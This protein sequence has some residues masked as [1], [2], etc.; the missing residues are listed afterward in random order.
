[1]SQA[2]YTYPILQGFK[3]TPQNPAGHSGVDIGT[4][5]GTPITAPM[6]GDIISQGFEPWGG[7]VNE[8]VTDRFGDQEVLSFL[9]TSRL[10]PATGH[11][12][13]GAI[14]GATGAPPP[15]GQYGSGAHLH[16]EESFGSLA[17]YMSSYNPQHPTAT[18]FPINPQ[19]VLGTLIGGGSG[20]SSGGSDC[21]TIPAYS[22][23]LAACQSGGGSFPDCL[24]SCGK[25][26]NCSIN[27]GVNVGNPLDTVGTDIQAGLATAG[28][29]LKRVGMF[30]LALSAIV[31][32]WYMVTHGRSTGASVTKIVGRIGQS[33]V[34]IQAS[35]KGGGQQGILPFTPKATSAATPDA[36]PAAAP[37]APPFVNAIRNAPANVRK[38]Y[39]KAQGLGPK[40]KQ[41]VQAAKFAQRGLTRA[42]RQAASM[43][44]K[45]S[46]AAADITDIAAV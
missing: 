41:A 13:A 23:C 29:A 26:F 10:S 14:I 18:N 16:F 31:L 32:G 15:G 35:T 8:R 40:G 6:S 46:G 25:Q 3:W 38:N 43:A 4:P 12:P 30:V 5:Y 9:H 42:P 17:P 44:G 22:Q 24:I 2:W 1:M 45:A 37:A 27:S 33:P 7:Q 11:V 19:G 20:L 28:A 21:G 39:G 36:T 34:S